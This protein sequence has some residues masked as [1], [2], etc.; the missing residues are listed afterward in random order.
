MNAVGLSWPGGTVVIDDQ[1]H[2]HVWFQQIVMHEVGHMVDFFHLSPADLHDE[3]AEIYGTPWA[4]MGHNFNNG[5][6]QAFSSYV[7][8][9]ASYPLTDPSWLELRMLLG[10]S[11]EIPEKLI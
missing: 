7:A 11:S 2:D 9:D 4:V 3:V 1:V 6:I 8:Y 10:G 5:F